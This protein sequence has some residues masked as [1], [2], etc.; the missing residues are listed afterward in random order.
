MNTLDLL[1]TAAGGKAIIT[2]REAGEILGGVSLKR[3]RNL[4]SEGNE[5]IPTM[6]IG[7]R[8]FVCLTDLADFVDRQRLGTPTVPDQP[9]VSVKTKRRAVGRPKKI[10]KTRTRPSNSGQDGHEN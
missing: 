3:L 4:R 8:R 7:G 9:R 6:Q 10:V 1:M 2:E 5:L